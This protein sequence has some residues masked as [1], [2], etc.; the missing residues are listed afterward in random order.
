MSQEAEDILRELRSSLLFAPDFPKRVSCSIAEWELLTEGERRA[1]DQ[2]SLE[3]AQ[4]ARTEYRRW[5]E[6]VRTLGK[7]RYTPA[8]PL[9]A[10]L[11]RDCALKPVRASVG[12]ALLAMDDQASY[13]ALE[14]LIEDREPISV[15]LGIRAVFRRNPLAAFDRFAPLFG[16]QDITAVTIGHETLSLFVPSM[17]LADGTPCWIESEAPSWFKQDLRWLALCAG[18]C[19]DERLGDPARMALRHADPG[20]ALRALEAARAKRPPPTPPTTCA[21]GDLVARYRAGDHL[22][23]WREARAFSAIAGDLRAEIA[24]LAG[25]TMLRTARNVTLISERLQRAGWQSLGPM[26]TLPE[27]ADEARIAAIEQMTGARLPPSL[28]AFWRVVGGVNWVW[29]CDQGAGP[30]VADLPLAGIDTDALSIEPCCT[31]ESLCFEV[32]EE[33]KDV[34]HPDL[35]GPFRLELAPDRLHKMQVSGGPPYAIELP[36]PGA[37]PL[38]RQED[39]A[40]PFVDYLRDCFAWAGFP[41]LKHHTDHAAARRFVDILGRGLEPF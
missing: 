5:E 15:H 40:L 25:E 30:V 32:W 39:H 8:I 2:A 20:S 6:D 37:D 14:S 17:V 33:Q 1:L 21:I 36:F 7:A 38:F 26:R 3:A 41:H 16:E 23:T 28:D 12:H 9:L 4:R 24:A 34:L 19:R 11:W 35:I 27:P 31:I 29:D 22:G 10:Q 13:D 18:L